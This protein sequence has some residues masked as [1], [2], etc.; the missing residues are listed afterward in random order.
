MFIEDKRTR[1]YTTF[2]DLEIGDYFI[3]NSQVFVK[4]DNQLKEDTRNCL[5]LYDNK[6]K[7]LPPL[8]K[9]ERVE[10]KIVLLDDDWR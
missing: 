1:N 3:Y 10:T 8:L 6:L 4:I 5:N 7:I 2:E 9:V